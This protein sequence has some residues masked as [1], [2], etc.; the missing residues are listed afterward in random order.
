MMG[1]GHRLVQLAQGLS[2]F[3]RDSYLLCLLKPGHQ[4]N[5]TRYYRIN[6]SW[7]LP[8]GIPGSLAFGFLCRGRIASGSI[9]VMQ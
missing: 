6:V 4:D 9:A 5:R 2:V 8:C 7:I 1:I 3:G